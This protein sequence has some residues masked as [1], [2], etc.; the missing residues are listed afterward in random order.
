M[1]IILLIIIL[2]NILYN[3]SGLYHIILLIMA[4]ANLIYSTF[5]LIGDPKNMLMRLI[6]IFCIISIII[7]VYYNIYILFIRILL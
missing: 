2:I 3:I 1:Y 6:Q 7:I 4:I 5:Y